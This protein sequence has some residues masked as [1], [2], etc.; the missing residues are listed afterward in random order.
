MPKESS[1]DNPSF[2]ESE[3]SGRAAI[4]PPRI[5]YAN[6][7]FKKSSN[8]HEALVDVTAGKVLWQRNLGSKVHAPGTPEEMER[9]HEVAMRSDLVK[10]E[11]Q[12]LKLV[13]GTE[14]VCEPWPYGKDGIND[15]ERLFQVI[16]LLIQSNCSA[17]SSLLRLIPRRS[18]LLSTTMHTLSTFPALSTEYVRK[19]LESS[20][21]P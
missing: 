6:F 19:S 5:I 8:F 12:R 3:H 11:I 18:I 9:M 21:F 15:D 17:T 16:P 14:V 2:L 7:Y 4:P 13:E 1:S 20:D 10:K